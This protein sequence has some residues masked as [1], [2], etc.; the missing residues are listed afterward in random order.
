MP[1]RAQHRGLYPFDWQQ[2]S[3]AV[4]FKRAHGR[5]EHCGRPHVSGSKARPFDC[6]LTRGA[7]KVRNDRQ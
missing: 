7:G 3:R 2:L 4:R 1:I 6:S 5:C